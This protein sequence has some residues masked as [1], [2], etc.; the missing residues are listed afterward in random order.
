MYS[1]IERYMQKIT[2]DDVN[3]FAKKK[4]IILTDSELN[5]TYDFIKKNWDKILSNPNMLNLS[6]YKNNYS[7]ENFIKINDLIKEYYSKYRR[8]I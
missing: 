1:I 5:F 7:D 8:F 4:S 3:E 2:K 6:R